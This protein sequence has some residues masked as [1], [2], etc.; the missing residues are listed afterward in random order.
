MR[1][2]MTGP[3][4]LSCVVMCAGWALAGAG[5]EEVFEQSYALSA[6]GAVSLE[7][8]NGDVSIEGWERDEVEIHAV[9]SASSPEL[10]SGLE[11]QVN[12]GANEVRIDTRYPKTRGS[13]SR[14]GSFTKVEYTLMVP[15]TAKLDG[16]DLVNGNLT[17][18]GVEGGLEAETVNGNISIRECAGSA[19]LNTVN[20]TIEAYIDRL[21]HGDSL[22][23]ESVNGRLDLYLAGSVGADLRAE[24]VNGR[25]HNDLGINVRKGKYV[26]SDFHGSVGGGGAEV[27]LETVNGS[28]TVHG[29]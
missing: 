1:S 6:G 9:K 27:S 10:L 17:V 28:I 24:S 18:V 13:D 14:E 20:G 22:E 12:A 19:E 23:L 4:V 8:I 26:G 11:I 5:Y 21:A 15:R 3:V 29:R 7:N 16:V 2:K 25:L